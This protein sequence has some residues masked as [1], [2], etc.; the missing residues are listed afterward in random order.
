MSILSLRYILKELFVEKTRMVLTILAIAW[1]TFAIA[2]M[3]SIG[4]GLRIALSE[5]VTNSGNNLLIVSG[6]S[7]GHAYKGRAPD[8]PINL[9]KADY[10]AI[11]S[12]PNIRLLALYTR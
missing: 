3:L 10:R 5:A 9:N 11:A 6:E 12:L 1:G 4:E 8:Q 2:S 7:T